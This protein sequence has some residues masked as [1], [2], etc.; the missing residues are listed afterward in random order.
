MTREKWLMVFGAG[1]LVGLI[2]A[3]LSPFGPIPSRAAAEQ[4]AKDEPPRFQVSAFAYGGCYAPNG[5]EQKYGH[6]AYFVDTQKGD[7]W[8]V[9]GDGKPKRLGKLE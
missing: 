4:A 8:A 6:G 2:V 1:V 3:F 7:V 5:T 9:F